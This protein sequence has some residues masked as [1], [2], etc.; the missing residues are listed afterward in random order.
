VADEP[1]TGIAFSLD[2]DGRARANAGELELQLGEAV[3]TWRDGAFRRELQCDASPASFSGSGAWHFFEAFHG[4]WLDGSPLDACAREPLRFVAS[5]NYRECELQFDRSCLEGAAVGNCSAF[6]VLELTFD[7]ASTEPESAPG[8]APSAA[9][10][11]CGP[12]PAAC[13][14]QP[15]RGSGEPCTGND[16]CAA[17]LF[18]DAASCA[19]PGSCATLPSF[20][21]CS[22]SALAGACGCDG[23]SHLSL[24]FAHFVAA[25]ATAGECAPAGSL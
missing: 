19:G 9:Q 10:Q 13:G 7:A 1:A 24:C 5:Y 25:R 22:A 4:V 23:V 6:G 21:E 11:S 3:F 20:D 14:G 2:R 12:I 17:G 15:C 18:C 16:E 8:A